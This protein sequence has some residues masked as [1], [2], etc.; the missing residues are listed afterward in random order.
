MQYKDW[1]LSGARER[2]VWESINRQNP[3][4]LGDSENIL[5][6]MTMENT[7]HYAFIQTHKVYNSNSEP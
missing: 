4:D 5:Y 3:E 1:L 7:C 2:K 6:N